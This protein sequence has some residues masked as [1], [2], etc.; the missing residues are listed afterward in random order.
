M[1]GL[2]K[3]KQNDAEEFEQIKDSLYESFGLVKE[4]RLE[5]DAG[6][7]L[8][9]ANPEKDQLLLS[10]IQIKVD[11]V[12]AA[13]GITMIKEDGQPV[14][15]RRSLSQEDLAKVP[16]DADECYFVNFTAAS[17]EIYSCIIV[18]PDAQI[19]GN[20]R[21]FWWSL[22]KMH[23]E[24][25]SQAI[26]YTKMTELAY[27]HVFAHGRSMWDI[28][29]EKSGSIDNM[30][31]QIVPMRNLHLDVISQMKDGAE[32]AAASLGLD[33]ALAMVLATQSEDPR[34]EAAAF[35]RFKHFLWQPGE[36]PQ[37]FYQ[38]SN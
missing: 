8:S 16:A 23:L 22:A 27:S 19:Y 24:R 31:D 9:F 1:F 30:R 11:L 15:E 37:E 10:G 3:K 36:E 13:N 18:Q 2:F 26:D 20:M 14:T 32:N 21:A 35:N 33:I 28:V 38:Y 5:N 34:L 4:L 25:I 29:V 7:L 12:H 6:P 17:G